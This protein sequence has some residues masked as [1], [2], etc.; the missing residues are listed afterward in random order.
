MGAYLFAFLIPSFLWI[1]VAKRETRSEEWLRDRAS[2]NFNPL[3]KKFKAVHLLLTEYHAIK[4][5][6]GMVV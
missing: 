3:N 6:W 2:H 1:T 5:C 4:A